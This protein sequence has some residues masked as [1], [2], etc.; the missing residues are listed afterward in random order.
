M[1]YRNIFLHHSV[2]L[3]SF[4]GT[5]VVVGIGEAEATCHEVYSGL[6]K[7]TN[8]MFCKLQS[9]VLKHFFALPLNFPM[10]RT[11]SNK[12]LF[13]S[14]DICFHLYTSF[15]NW[16]TFGAQAHTRFQWMK[17]H[18]S[19]QLKVSISA[20]ISRCSFHLLLHLLRIP[21]LY[22][23]E[24]QLGEPSVSN[25]SPLQILDLDLQVCQ[26]QQQHQMLQSTSESC[27]SNWLQ[28]TPDLK[29]SG[30]ISTW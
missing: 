28:L 11:G 6:P 8:T 12:C 19:A 21:Q 4:K 14:S 7:W 17:P 2:E 30:P 16:H 27:S 3:A 26:P 18:K 25:T 10:Q 5:D 1:L 22:C 20:S 23:Q 15:R 24:M 29:A 9:T 13:S